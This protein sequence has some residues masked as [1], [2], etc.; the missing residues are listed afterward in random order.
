VLPNGWR[1]LQMAYCLHAQ[2]Q[3]YSHFKETTSDVEL[4]EF[5]H[6]HKSNHFQVRHY[7]LGS[8]PQ[9]RTLFEQLRSPLLN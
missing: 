4:R 2:F 1:I 8:H 9:Q 3:T 7:N 5:N 6:S